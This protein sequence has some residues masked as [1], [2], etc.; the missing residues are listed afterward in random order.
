LLLTALQVILLAVTKSE[1]RLAATVERDTR[2]LVNEM[3]E[4]YKVLLQGD[5][6]PAIDALAPPST[7]WDKAQL[8]IDQVSN[9]TLYF[10]R[11]RQLSLRR[12]AMRAFKMVFHNLHNTTKPGAS[13]LQVLSL[14]IRAFVGEEQLPDVTSWQALRKYINIDLKRAISE[15]DPTRVAFVKVLSGL[16]TELA[17]VQRETVTAESQPLVTMIYDWLVCSCA[18]ARKVTIQ[19]KSKIDKAANPVEHARDVYDGD[20]E[21]P[22]EELPAAAAD[23]ATA[24]D[25]EDG[26]GVEA[27]FATAEATPFESEFEGTDEE[28][29]AAAKIQAGF[30]G[31][32]VRKEMKAGDAPAGETPAAADGGDAP[33]AAAAAAAVEDA[34]EVDVAAAVASVAPTEA[35]PVTEDAPAV[36]AHAADAAAAATSVGEVEEAP[37][38]EEAAAAPAAEAT[39]A[40]AP[41]E[42]LPADAPPAG[43]VEEAPAADAPPP[44]E[45]E[46]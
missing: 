13:T 1:D 35:E 21:D 41:T 28:N 39:D 40:P 26:G 5:V 22:E 7:I 6:P 27:A 4:V 43:E 12:E 18:M 23:Q 45:V 17:Q 38:T 25:A 46:E 37:P 20:E 42:A 29:L 15:Y 33:A 16:D 11:F 32:K 36:E 8:D 31:Q 3:E 9:T 19:R 14:M 30:R 10:L 2:K 34:G 24:D 44:D